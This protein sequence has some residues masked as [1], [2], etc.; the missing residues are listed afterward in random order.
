MENGVEF[1]VRACLIGIGATALLDLWSEFIRR[2]FRVPAPNWAMVGRWVGNFANGVFAHDDMSL[3]PRVKREL[4]IGWTTHYAVGVAY[5]MLLLS[6]FGM[7]W[8]RA[9]TLWP[10]LA[11]GIG[12][13]VAPL[14]VMLPCMGAGF[15]A[16]R[17]QKPNR[18]RARTV[19][20]HTIFGLGLYFSALF[21]SILIHG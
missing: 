10:A 19:M 6:I 3:A 15:A 7:A 20:S 17:A 12:A 2:A 9:P 11:V 16:S 1:A 21:S 8:A 4:I 14:F 13:I 5:G 18:V